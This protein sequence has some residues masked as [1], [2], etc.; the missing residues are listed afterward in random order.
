MVNNK[1]DEANKTIAENKNVGT[2][3]IKDKIDLKY[4][5]EMAKQVEILGENA[6][7]VAHEEYGH[8][9]QDQAGF[10]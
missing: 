2:R 4:L 9:Q 10:H 6:P 7:D 3:S 1:L 8:G 5:V